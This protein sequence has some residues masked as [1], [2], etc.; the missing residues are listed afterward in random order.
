MIP[1]LT[2]AVGVVKGASAAASIV[3]KIAEVITA[4]FD[5]LYDWGT[6]PLKKREYERSESSKDRDVQRDIER[7]VGVDKALSEQRMREQEHKS[8]RRMREQKHKNDLA[9]ERETE[10]VRIITEIEQLK[11]DKEFERMK[12]VSDA[13]MEYQIQL[14][15]IN[16]EAVEVIGIMRI[17]L[18]KRAYD[19]IQEKSQQFY[20][21][22]KLALAD[23]QSQLETI[24]A[25]E[26]PDSMKDILSGGVAEILSTTI[27]DA[28]QFIQ[29][30]NDDMA[31]LNKDI[32]LI[33]SNGQEFIQR[34]LEHFKT[35]D[36]PSEIIQDV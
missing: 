1:P 24:H 17:E 19:L 5:L 12:S 32:N 28:T 23:A 29:Q 27:R 11:K 13:M 3:S 2:A 30:L 25:S 34:H 7:Q 22:K 4:P 20:E 6:E 9:I 8:Q 21:H 15:R 26:L 16:V 35:I 10:V 31:F 14:T 18:Q 33:T 36:L